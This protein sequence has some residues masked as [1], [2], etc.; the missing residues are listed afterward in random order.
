VLLVDCGF[1]LRSFNER[2]AVLGL[3]PSDLT[4]VLVTHE[5]AD[6]IRG[7]GP[8]V[9]KYQVPVYMTRGTASSSS[10]GRINGQHQLVEAG[11]SYLLGDIQVTVNAVPHDAREPVQF[12]FSYQS[13]KLGVLTDVGTITDDVVRAYQDLDALVLEANHCPEMLARGPYP[14]SLKQRVGGAWGH[15]SNQQSVSF[16]EQIN[17]KKLQHL[18]LAHI[19]QKNNSSERVQAAFSHLTEV[20]QVLC[21]ANQEQGFDWLQIA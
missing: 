4:A 1:S 9:R 21:L 8:L 6:H 18:V 14:T 7:I 5:H 16:L 10:L 11:R 3:Q 17:L 15:L 13:K 2:L 12:V 20:V 19:S